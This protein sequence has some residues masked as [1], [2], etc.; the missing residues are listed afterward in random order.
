VVAIS[1]A[2]SAIAKSRPLP[3]SVYEALRDLGAPEPTEVRE[4][5]EVK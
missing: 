2:D 5:N 1:I 3:E 4:I